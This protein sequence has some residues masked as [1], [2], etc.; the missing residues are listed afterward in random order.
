MKIELIEMY[1]D[2]KRITLAEYKKKIEL[3]KPDLILTSRYEY[4]QLASEGI[5]ADLSEKMKNSGMKEEDFYP[6]MIDL[7]KRS[8]SGKLYGLAPSFQSAFLYYNEDLF[9]KAGVELPRDGMTLEEV[10]K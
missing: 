7:M 4:D 10:Y 2:N 3:N 8:G 9:N 1:P 5:F 6:G